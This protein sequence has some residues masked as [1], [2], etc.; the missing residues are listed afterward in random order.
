MFSY[1]FLE[2][3]KEIRKNI[4]I[5]AEILFEILMKKENKNSD[6]LDKE[7]CC[8]FSF[9]FPLKYFIKFKLI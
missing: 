6:I 8:K 1:F 5:I 3:T 9:N 7:R 2:K 4:I